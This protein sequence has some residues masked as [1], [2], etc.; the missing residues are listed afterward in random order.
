M[1]SF[2]TIASALLVWNLIG[3]AAFVAQITADLGQLALTD[4]ATADAFRAMPQWAWGAY[5][6]AVFTGTA[7]AIALFAP[8]QDRLG[9]FR[10]LAG[11]DHRPIRLD[12]PEL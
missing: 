6:I 11:G 7:A 5:A 2:R 8:P 3:I 1:R 10:H 12:I 9:A 4:P